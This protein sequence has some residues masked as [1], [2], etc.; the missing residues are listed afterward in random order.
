MIDGIRGGKDFENVLRYFQCRIDPT[1]KTIT[2]YKIH[3]DLLYADTGSYDVDIPDT[4][5]GLRVIIAA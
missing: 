4:L 3:Y 1:D 5:V 2:L